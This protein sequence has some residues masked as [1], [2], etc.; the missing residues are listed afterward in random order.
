MK[1]LLTALCAL[2]L[3]LGLRSA[4]AA[5]PAPPAAPRTATDDPFR[6]GPQHERLQKLVGTWDA[7]LV[8]T[9]ARGVEQRTSGTLTTEAHTGFHTIETFRGE[10]MGAPYQGRGTNG[11]CSARK[12]YFTFWTDSMTSSPM[13]LHGDYDAEKRELVLR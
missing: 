13:V 4:L 7:V 12:Q 5:E 11:Y 10:F 2:T 3:A 6:P 9:D 8:R 1:L